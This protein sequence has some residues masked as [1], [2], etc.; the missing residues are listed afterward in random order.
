MVYP[1]VLVKLCLFPEGFTTTFYSAFNTA[2]TLIFVRF[3]VPGLMLLG[4][5][6]LFTSLNCAGV[7]SN[8][9]MHCLNMVCQVRTAKE[10]LAAELCGLVC[11]AD[12][13]ANSSMCILVLS[14]A[15]WPLRSMEAPVKTTSISYNLSVIH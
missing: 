12:E 1:H 6:R 15:R 9:V 14:K 7:R 13:W 5:E 2:S 4:C 8:F 10:A 3:L 11:V